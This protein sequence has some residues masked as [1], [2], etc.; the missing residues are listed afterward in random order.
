MM[1]SKKCH[2]AFQIFITIRDNKKAYQEQLEEHNTDSTEKKITKELVPMDPEEFDPLDFITPLPTPVKSTLTLAPT[3]HLTKMYLWFSPWDYEFGKYKE[4]EFRMFV[5]NKKITAISQQY[6]YSDLGWSKPENII[7][8]KSTI[9]ALT[10]MWA[11][12]AQKVPF[13]DCVVD[14]FV[15]SEG[16]GR[17]IEFNPYGAHLSSGSSLFNWLTHYDILYGINQ[18]KP[19]TVRLVGKI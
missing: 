17:L 10:D 12:I 7:K 8:L 14:A 6:W 3:S 13:L 5:R 9:R 16:K 19:F 11:S 18:K 2:T 1:E 4:N 15:T